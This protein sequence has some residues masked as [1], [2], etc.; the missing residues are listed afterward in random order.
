MYGLRR[1][2][3]LA[4][5]LTLM[6]CDGTLDG[7]SF[8]TSEDVYA[9]PGYY[10]QPPYV[11]EHYAAPGYI[12]PYPYSPGFGGPYVAEPGWGGRNGWR[13]H[14]WREG[15]EGGFSH[16]D[17]RSF[18]QPRQDPG[19]GSRVAVQPQST[20]P[21]APPPIASQPPPA[22]RPQEDQNRKLLDQ[23]GFRPSR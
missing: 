19:N 20:A 21:A 22:V 4:M 17:R 10:G 13:E 6:A 18:S 3:V 23:L 2:A 14:E 11:Q 1:A 16:E 9:S 8:S 7:L 5:G 12:A 15:R